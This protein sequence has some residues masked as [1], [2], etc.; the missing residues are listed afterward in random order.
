MLSKVAIIEVIGEKKTG[1][2]TKPWLS[3]LLVKE[4]ITRQNKMRKDLKNNGISGGMRAKKSMR[5]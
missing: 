4:K 1:R 3:P 2:R 5:R